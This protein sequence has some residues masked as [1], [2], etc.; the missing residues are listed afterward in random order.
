MRTGIYPIPSIT[1]RLLHEI[2]KNLGEYNRIIAITIKNYSTQIV[3]EDPKVYFQNGTADSNLP[4]NRVTN[5]NGLVWSARKISGAMFGTRGVIVYHIKDRKVSL[6]FMWSVPFNSVFYKNLWNV[7][8]YD[9]FVKANQDLIDHL[10]HDNSYYGDSSV[11]HG[12]I[13]S[14]LRCVGSMGAS[15]TP[16]VE[17]EIH[18][19][20]PTIA[21]AE[22]LDGIVYLFDDLQF[23]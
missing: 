8:V 13:C 1:Y 18:D 16:T 19:Y 4:L 17:V 14:Y 9:G 3:L 10:C 21:Y 20:N 23:V 7:K 22:L 2:L 12:T 11:Y 5:G 6:V 15:S